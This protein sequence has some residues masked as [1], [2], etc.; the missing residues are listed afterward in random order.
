MNNHSIFKY[1]YYDDTDGGGVV[2]HANY[3]KY[4]DHA[5]SDFLKQKG[6]DL[7]T[8]QRDH[9]LLFAVTRADLQY[10]RP[11]RLSDEL[12]ITARLENLSAVS[13]SFN[14]NVLRKGG[15]LLLEAAVTVVCLN[16]DQFKPVK[17]PKM[18][19]EKLTRDD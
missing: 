1:V 18:I 16:S 4:L 6:F 17:I 14:Q 7:Q 19:R 10:H 13:M 8:L 3:L 12:E 9:K 5:R 2:Y 11:A 15:D